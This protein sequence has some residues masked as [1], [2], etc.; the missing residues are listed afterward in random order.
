MGG[1]WRIAVICLVLAII[2]SH[3]MYVFVNS[4]GSH[5][6]HVVLAPPEISNRETGI[7]ALSLVPSFSVYKLALL[8]AH[9]ALWCECLPSMDNVLM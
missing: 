4:P 9:W 1:G 5:Q 8:T 3:G 7:S 6:G 2:C